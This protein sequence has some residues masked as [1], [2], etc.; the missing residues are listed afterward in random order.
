MKK[1]DRVKAK[2]KVKVKFEIKDV[3]EHEGFELNDLTSP[4][5]HHLA[6]KSVIQHIFNK[7]ADPQFS[8]PV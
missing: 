5:N 7:S 6:G 3:S 2:F 1:K 4:P 8:Y